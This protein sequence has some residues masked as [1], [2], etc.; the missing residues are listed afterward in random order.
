LIYYLDFKISAVSKMRLSLK[1]ET[2][3]QKPKKE[4]KVSEAKIR[5]KILRTN[6][7]FSLNFL[8]LKSLSFE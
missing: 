4:R 1:N 8:D 2:R 6:F 3:F 7:V 5:G